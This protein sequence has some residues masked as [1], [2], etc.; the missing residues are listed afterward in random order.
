MH[1]DAE[2]L[3]LLALGDEH[4]YSTDDV[5]HVVRC[6]TC[7]S[8]VESVKL[9]GGLVAESAAEP[10]PAPVAES[11]WERIAERT[12]QG[13]A[14]A[15]T[16]TLTARPGHRARAARPR[17]ARLRRYGPTALAG[18]AAGVAATVLVTTAVQPRALPPGAST[19]VATTHLA[20]QPG[21]P[22]AATGTVTFVDEGGGRLVAR[23]AMSGMFAPDGLFELW[24]YDGSAVMIPLGVTRGATVDL[25][26][27][28]GVTLRDYPVVD[29]SHQ[30]TG[31]QEHGTSV[32]RGQTAV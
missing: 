24:L 21:A 28:A 19:V 4:D 16:R 23:L 1:P 6:S 12:G 22:A 31:Q 14:T 13:P 11:V 17:W 2:R 10:P 29:V 20:P 5:L 8:E 7:R 3:I 32:L 9:V 18:A 30:S 27:P 26:V 25:P 15:T